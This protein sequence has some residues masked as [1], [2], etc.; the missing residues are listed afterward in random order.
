MRNMRIRTYNYPQGRLTDH[1]IGL[2]LY[3][4]PLIMEGNL[5]P[6]IDALRRAVREKTL[7]TPILQDNDDD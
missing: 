3:N 2:S 1:R 7:E 6:L 5:D 4:L